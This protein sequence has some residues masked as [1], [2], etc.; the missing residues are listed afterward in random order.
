MCF[1]NIFGND[2]NWKSCIPGYDILEVKFDFTIP[3]WFHRIIQNY[4][5]KR[6]SVSKFVLGLEATNLA[7]D[8]EKINNKFVFKYKY[9]ISF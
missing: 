5:L 2:Y 9:L 1:N 6:L 7:Y 4:Q 3:P 8:Y